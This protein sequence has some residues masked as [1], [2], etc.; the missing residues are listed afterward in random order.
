MFKKDKKVKYKFLTRLPL[1]VKMLLLTLIIGLS[2]LFV[3]DSFKSKRLKDIF[4]HQLIERLDIQAKQGQAFFNKH[5]DAHN[6][7]VKVFTSQR[8]F[9][10]YITKKTKYI[11]LSDHKVTN[12]RKTPPPWFPSAEIVNLF[13]KAKYYVLVDST[14]VIREVYNERRGLLDEMNPIPLDIMEKLKTQN[15]ILTII[16]GMPYVISSSNITDDS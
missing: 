4:N 14:G 8:R 2:L 6:Q 15:D 13:V 7:S 10:N 5:I 9:V 12:Y 1:T 3:L 11:W 16:N